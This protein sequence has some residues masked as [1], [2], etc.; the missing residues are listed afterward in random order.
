MILLDR[1]AK[2]IRANKAAELLSSDTGP[3]RLHKAEIAAFHPSFSRR[4]GE[5]VQSAL[6]GVPAATMSIPHPDDGRL[7]TLFV[8]SVRSRDIDRFAS[9]DMQDAAVMIFV[10]DLAGPAEVPPTWLMD[11]YG[12]TLAEARVALP[13]AL[14]RSV[15][16]IAT[17]LNI[18]PNTVKTHLRRIFVKT[19][20]R[21]QAELAGLVAPL[22]L[23]R[24]E[25]A[26]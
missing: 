9:L 18:S 16:E 14:G 17:Q 25:V 3:L 11:A 12:L 8:S 24:G 10:F 5:L 13:A 21:G 2:V 1:S 6:R 26:T 22:R 20:V 4:L 15:A 23:M 7:V 19:G